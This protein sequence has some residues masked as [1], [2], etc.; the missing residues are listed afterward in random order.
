[1]EENSMEDDK[2]DTDLITDCVQ[3]FHKIECL[4]RQDISSQNL[5]SDETSGKRLRESSEE[6]V[7]DSFSLVKKKKAKKILERR[8]EEG[9]KLSIN[10]YADDNI[11][12]VCL[13]SAEILPKQMALAKI[14]RDQ[15][16]KNIIKIK[17]KGPYKV[18]IHLDNTEES[19]KLINCPK[20]KELKIKAQSTDKCN[21]V[22]GIIRG[23]DIELSMEEF[24][25][26]LNQED[27]VLAAKRLKKMDRKGNWV[28]GEIVRLCF[29][30][31]QCP[32]HVYAYGCRFEVER[33]VYPVTQCSRCWKFG[34][35]KRFC[36]VKKDLCPKCG[37][38]HANCEIVDFKCPN[39]SGPHMALNK[40]CPSFLKEKRIRII[41]SKENVMYREALHI[42]LQEEKHQQ[43]NRAEKMRA[44][45]IITVEKL[46][47]SRTYSDAVKRVVLPE[48]NSS[49]GEENEIVNKVKK[50][51]NKKTKKAKPLNDVNEEESE[52][53]LE[54]TMS[55]EDLEKRKGRNFEFKKLWKKV[56]DI[57]LADGKLEIKIISLMKV[58]FDGFKEAIIGFLSGGDIIKTFTDL[59]NG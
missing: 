50:S 8:N 11:H 28:D 48:Q 57:I 52:I 23:V 44:G 49:S 17:Y 51:K 43:G 58:V 40:T 42:Y 24:I 14:L 25:T 21:W 20:L 46:C 41:M 55:V 33:F 3:D 26:S 34:H 12:K 32:T 7:D 18:L 13:T 19:E 27:K 2:S 38:E 6:N 35:I 9:Q 53:V 16:I 5:I 29:Q 15:N 10:S 4:N 30:S 37:N 31:S 1:M 36:P 22:Y 54:P 47:G 56:K 45:D 39:C 59:Y